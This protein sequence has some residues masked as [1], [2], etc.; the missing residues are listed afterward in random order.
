M[1]EYISEKF[2]PEMSFNVRVM[3]K[4]SPEPLTDLFSYR[5]IPAYNLRSQTHGIL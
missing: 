3:N 4:L 2:L 5:G 1:D